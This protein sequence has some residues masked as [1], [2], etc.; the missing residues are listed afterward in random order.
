MDRVDCDSFD[1]DCFRLR[2]IRLARWRTTRGLKSSTLCVL[3]VNML[4]VLNFGNSKT[5]KFTNSEGTYQRKGDDPFM[6]EIDGNKD[7]I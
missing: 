3:S 5:E 2:Y 6:N 1:A 7:E 4:I